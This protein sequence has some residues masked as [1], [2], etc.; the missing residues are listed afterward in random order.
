MLHACEAHDEGVSA[1][2]EIAPD[3]AGERETLNA[4]FAFGAYLRQF[5][6]GRVL[7]TLDR[8]KARSGWLDAK[9]LARRVGTA[10]QARAPFALV[11]LGDGEGS[12]LKLSAADEAA[13]ETLYDRNRQEFVRIWFGESFDWRNGPFLRDAQNLPQALAQC[14]VIG[15]PY[16]SWVRH[17]YGISSLRG[18]PSLVNVIRLLQED[19]AVGQKLVCSQHAHLDLF[20]EGYLVPLIKAAGQLSVITCLPEVAELLRDR[21]N[22]DDVRLHLIPAEQLSLSILGEQAGAGV[23]YPD[24]YGCIQRELAVPHAGRLFLVAAG[25]LGKFYCA[26][27]RANGGIALDIGSLVDGWVGRP[28]RPGYGQRLKL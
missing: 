23:H 2:N 20:Q 8:Q 10:I 21:F 14:D 28:T 27:I 11:R 13:Y 5:P 16:E 9:A 6:L 18:V 17:E 25:L 26:A 7:I 12:M 15:I 19:D 24:A 3:N 22:L 1:L 4:M